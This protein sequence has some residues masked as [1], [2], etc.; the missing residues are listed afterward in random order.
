MVEV[1]AESTLISLGIFQYGWLWTLKANAVS[2][3]ADGAELSVTVMPGAPVL[4]GD[5]A[6]M[7]GGYPYPI[8]GTGNHQVL[9]PPVDPANP[10]GAFWFSSSSATVGTMTLD[11]SWI[12]GDIQTPWGLVLD[13]FEPDPEDGSLGDPVASVTLP[14]NVDSVSLPVSQSPGEVLLWRVRSPGGSGA[15]GHFEAS[16]VFS[17]AGYLA[18]LNVG[19]MS[20]GQTSAYVTRTPAVVTVSGLGFEPDEFVDFTLLGTGKPLIPTRIQTDETGCIAG[21]SFTVPP[22][23]AGTYLMQGV[24]ASS[25]LA[26][27]VTVAV[28][29][30]PLASPAVLA[31]DQ[32]PV[33]VAQTG[34]R[35]W[36]LQDA[37]PVAVG[38]IAQ[39]VMSRNPESATAPAA[40]RAFAVDSLTGPGSQAVLWEG[41]KRAFEWKFS[42]RLDD[43]G[44]IDKLIQYSRINRRFWLIDHRNQAWVVAFTTLDMTPIRN[45]GTITSHQYSASVLI[46]RGPIQL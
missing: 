9:D 7:S 14:G 40:P 4:P 44:T 34:V 13:V 33:P 32:V 29:N 6:G 36:V 12:A 11:L 37:L 2:V 18:T 22:V 45:Y 38:G 46:F 41:G 21:T 42:G 19:D 30:S 5:T 43:I 10:D 20:T 39:L 24:G 27:V 8:S 1:A 23:A 31:A 35:Q 16:W 28:E 26:G 3:V 17:S 15:G 25:G